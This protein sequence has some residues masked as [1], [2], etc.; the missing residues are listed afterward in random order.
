[1]GHWEAAV[2]EVQDGHQH[3]DERKGLDGEE[4]AALLLVGACADPIT[5]LTYH[6]GLTVLSATTTGCSPSSYADRGA[7][8]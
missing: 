8:K 4:T 2:P 7:Q 1:V 5:L 3:W 6:A